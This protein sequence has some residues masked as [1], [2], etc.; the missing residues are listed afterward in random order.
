[1]TGSKGGPFQVVYSRAILQR[2]REL[3]HRAS[4]VGLGGEYADSVRAMHAR[5]TAD[6]LGWGDPQYRLPVLGVLMC[7]R[8]HW[9]LQISYGIDEVNRLVFLK[10][11]KARPGSQLDVG[12]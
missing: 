3:G 1:M 2:L 7:H 11:I 8:M 4:G 6:P 5:L 12:P 9:F 10:E